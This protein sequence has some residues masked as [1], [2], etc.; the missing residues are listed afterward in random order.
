MLIDA[1]LKERF[2][3]SVK[4]HHAVKAINMQLYRISLNYPHANINQNR[5]DIY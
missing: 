2:D 3:W 4:I 5:V 1:K